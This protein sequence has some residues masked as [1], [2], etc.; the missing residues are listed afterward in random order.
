MSSYFW[1]QNKSNR[2]DLLCG[3]PADY[4]VEEEHFTTF[5]CF[6]VVLG[7]LLKMCLKNSEV[8]VLTILSLSGFVIGQMAYSSVEVHQI[9]YP[10]LRTSSFSLYSYFSPLIIFMV[11]LDVDF[12]ILKNMFW[13]VLLTG[14]I[15]FS[16]ASIILGYVVIKFNKA[17]WDFQSCL[18][19][20]II[21]GITD[22]LR[23]VN[24]LKTIGIS[25]MYIDLIRGE[26]LI[27]CSITSVF[28]GNFRG[29]GIRFSIFRDLHIGIGLSLD[30]LGSIIFGYWCAKIIRCILADVFSNMLT[31][32]ILCFSMVYMTFY[33]VELLGMSGTL[34]L[35]AVGLNLDS[36]TFKP[37]I[38]FVI[39]KFLRIFSCVYEHL[40]Y[41]FFGIVIGC[42]ELDHYEFYTITFIVILF[43]TVNLV[44]LLTILLVSPILMHSSYEYNWR[45]GVI[46]TWSG[47]KGVFNL[48]LAP[49]IYN[50]AEQKVEVPQM[51]IL[52]VQV[53]SLLTMGIN[54]YVMT[55]SARKL[56]MC[57]LSL[58]R[59][60]A[61]QNATQHIQEIV[62]NTITLSKAEKI[63]TNVN[64]TL[65]EDKT[66]IEYI[67]VSHVS[68]K[69]MK[70]EST[71][72][73][74][75][76]EEA[77]LHVATIQMSSF[78][79]QRNSGILEIEA[80]RILI[81]AAKCYYSIQ[82]KFMSI[83]DVSTY[84]RTRSW[85]MKF[86]TVLTFLEYRKEKI[87][88]IPP[89]SNAFLTFIFHIVSSEEFEYTGQIINL[90]YIY[91]MIIHM[92][93]M[94]RDLNVSAL[95]SINY[96]FMFLYVLESTLK[97]II[98]KR[99]YFRQYW[100]T[101][102]FF[103]LVIG[104]IDIFCVYFV[105]LR[106]DNLALIQLTVIMGYLR[107]IRFLPL[108]KIIVPILI[109]IADVQI[110]KRLSLMYSITKGYIKSQEDAKLL[111]KQISI[112]E[113][114]YQK[115]YEI[116]ETNKQNAVKELG[117]IEHE[118]RDVVIALKT[119][120]AIRNVIA[121]ALKNLTFLC[122][123]GIIDKHESTE[124][125]K[126]LLKKLKALNNFPKAI[127]PPTPDKYLHNIIW[128]EGKD[129]LIDFFKE[130]AKLA[131]F[132][133]GDIICK[134][135][136]MPQG[137]YLIIS[138]MAI[139][140][141]LS[142][143]FGIESS[144]RPDRKSRDMFTEF[145]TTGDIIGELN[146]LLKREIEYTIICE[147]SL[148]ACFISL[149]DL[150]EGFDAFWPSLEYKIWLKLALSTAYQYFESSLTD[151][152]LSFQKCVMFNQ[153]YVETLSSYNEM[154]IDNMTMK[155][156]IIVYGSVIDTK[157]EEP[158]FAPCIIPTT[159]EQV[160]GTSDLSK[161]LII[162]AS[163]LTQRHS[164]TNVMASASTL[165]F[166]QPGDNIT[167]RQKMS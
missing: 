61:L 70:K 145:C 58:P 6:I 124:I 97:I 71:T 52:Y 36:L 14:L 79:K 49:D 8:T 41:T 138:G 4:L 102:E 48:L 31:N 27:I 164:N 125:N 167:G 33:I 60:M 96:Y 59:Q 28:L 74:A 50:L 146:C 117:L 84:M 16:S 44:R 135:G 95:I 42:G 73:E 160:Q 17:S 103:I 148:Q 64:W 68:H 159:C 83:Y 22:P 43:T 45:W 25:K 116:L 142:P 94:A 98:L 72:D 132:D 38:E 162:Q 12:Y 54:S 62:Q 107:I 140:H 46:I 150:Y 67:P 130:R 91:P 9:V 111:I 141:S 154:T 118:G 56:D 18:L 144:Q 69:D 30:I 51:F 165:V 120:Q 24:S 55:Q 13:Q 158:Y 127:P 26:S 104:I 29:N 149:E 89:E 23:S 39:T 3:Q 101:L 128:L 47:I 110:K 156:V 66:R 57:V 34:A 93:P 90:I 10:L 75:L 163:E 99:K 147:T 2:P 123:R 136:E 139:L 11:A 108:F 65:V 37:K 5:V 7:G 122:S 53:I 82:G 112:H 92:W 35:V 85:L 121:K 113:S 21:L 86:K 81:G 161:L 19:F 1:A 77:R 115:L 157:T 15:S 100:N 20:S 119:K 114:I 87:H 134:G 78:E 155:F 137:I 152:D 80:A 129:V 32:I 166:K 153:A 143:T 63:L 151:E 126:V 106:P 105:K 88:F 109:S 131:C 133:Y 76:I 40:I